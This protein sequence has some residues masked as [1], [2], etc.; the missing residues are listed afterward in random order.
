MRSFQY[1][2][3]RNQPYR[4]FTVIKVRDITLRSCREGGGGSPLKLRD[5][6]TATERCARLASA[7]DS[8]QKAH[9]DR[10]RSAAPGSLS[11]DYNWV[12]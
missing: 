1:H 8:P 2:H 10:S 5:S 12:T 6:I 3:L 11:I 4:H 9:E 7:H